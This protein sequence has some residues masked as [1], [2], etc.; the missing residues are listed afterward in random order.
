VSEIQVSSFFEL[1]KIATPQTKKLLYDARNL[2][3]FFYR[4]ELEMSVDIAQDL[5]EELYPKIKSLIESL[6]SL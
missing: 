1:T 2:H 3:R 6:D 5:F 4:G